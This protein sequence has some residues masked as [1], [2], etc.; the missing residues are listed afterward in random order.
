[1]G[2]MNMSVYIRRADREDLDTV[3]AWMEDPDFVHFL[4]G[5]ATRS[6]RR[7]REQIASLL[8][9]SNPGTV[10]HA[11]YL[12]LDSEEY[13]PVGFAA[14]GN[15]SWRNRSCSIDTYIGKKELRV[16]MVAAVNFARVMEYCFYELN[17]HRVNMFVYAFNSR[18]WRIVELSGAKRELT[19]KNHV[20]RDGK[21]YDMYGYGL[22]RCEYEELRKKAVKRFDGASLEDMMA[23]QRA[24]GMEAEAAE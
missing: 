19:L 8:G 2:K 7:I 3:V 17:L 20:S 22:L 12:I 1:M 18:S 9:R 11:V 13:G 5:D 16:G 10:P 6:P 14:V 4:Y 21:L 24:K 15:I 23:K